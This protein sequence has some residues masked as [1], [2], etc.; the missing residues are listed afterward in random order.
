MASPEKPLS[1]AR[2]CSA[3]SVVRP[4]ARATRPWASSACAVATLIPDV[5]REVGQL[6]GGGAC[7]GEVGELHPCLDQGE[8]DA[9]PADD[10]TGGLAQ[11]A[12]EEDDGRLRAVLRQPE[13]G[14]H[15]QAE[16]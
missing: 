1:A 9:G 14:E 3:A 10:A 5:A 15:P 8:Q 6:L 12:V 13:Q 2:A 16:G 11:G 4:S 7:S